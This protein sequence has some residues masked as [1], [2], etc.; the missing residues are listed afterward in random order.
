MIRPAKLWCDTE[1]AQ[2]AE[3]LSS[4]FRFQIP[5]GFTG[6]PAYDLCPQISL[7]CPHPPTSSQYVLACYCLRRA[8]APVD[9]E[10]RARHVCGN[11][12][13]HATRIVC[14]FRADRQQGGSFV[15]SFCQRPRTIHTLRQGVLSFAVDALTMR[16]A[17]VAGHRRQRQVL[18]AAM[19]RELQPSQFAALCCHFNNC[20]S[21]LLTRRLAWVPIAARAQASLTPLSAA[22]TG[23]SATT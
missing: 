3:T 16:M 12:V 1:T 13:H 6:K 23:A 10:A 7:L 2:E 17:F 9:A 18:N 20:G 14:Q 22:S 4:A 19:W 8:K 15:V 11:A 5:A 21:S